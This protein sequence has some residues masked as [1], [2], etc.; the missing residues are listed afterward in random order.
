MRIDLNLA[1]R[2]YEDLQRFYMRWIPLLL[3][4]AVIAFTLTG[5]AHL[6]YRETRKIDD[7]IAQEREEIGKLDKRRAEAQAMLHRPENAGTAAQAQF[8]NAL[9]AR[10]SFSWTQVLSDLEKITPSGVQVMS[11]RPELTADQQI[12]FR[13]TVAT[14]RRENAIELV[15]RME[16]SPS[17]RDAQVRSEV[18]ESKSTSGAPPIRFEIA[19]MYVM[20]PQLAAR[21]TR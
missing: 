4:L 14:N 9:F 3:I 1:S 18:M 7:Q 15:R 5:Y 20:R 8:L 19:T 11:M 21:S 12:Q 16:N 13:M 6:R 17:F 10:K 2:P